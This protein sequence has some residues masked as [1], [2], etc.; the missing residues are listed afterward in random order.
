MGYDPSTGSKSA[1]VKVEV[2]PPVLTTLNFHHE[3]T[4]ERLATIQ[5]R[6]LPVPSVGDEVAVNLL[7]GDRESDVDADTGPHYRVT[8]IFYQYNEI[9]MAPENKDG[10]SVTVNVYALP[11]DEWEPT[12]E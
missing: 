8:D 5:R 7:A 12:E 10:A 3:D 4:E 1:D 6:G 2:S 11:I 9:Q